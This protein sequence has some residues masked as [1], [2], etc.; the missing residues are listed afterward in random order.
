MRY[1][2]F[3]RQNFRAWRKKSIAGKR[4]RMKAQEIYEKEKDKIR[5]IVADD[6]RVGVVGT[7]RP[8]TFFTRLRTFTEDSLRKQQEGLDIA[9]SFQKIKRVAQARIARK[10]ARIKRIANDVFNDRCEEMMLVKGMENPHASI[11]PL[12]S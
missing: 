3:Y 5:D 2:H 1:A 4:M 10:N 7:Y 12:S 9:R 8:K 11:E 6:F